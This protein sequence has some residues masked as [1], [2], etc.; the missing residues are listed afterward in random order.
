MQRSLLL[1]DVAS[2]GAAPTSDGASNARQKFDDRP[3]LAIWE[4]TQACDLVCKH[5]RA[6]AQS[7][8]DRDELT[9]S[10][11]KRLL[12]ELA[13]AR[14]PLVVL[15]GGDPA[16]RPDL[17]ELVR[18]GVGR[19]INLALTPSATPLV[20]DALVRE[21]AAAGLS[22]LAISIDGSTAEVHDEFRGVVGSFAEAQ[23]ILATARAANLQTQINT[24]IHS[25]N[26]GEIASMARLV[27]NLG[28]R[29]WSVFYLVPTGRA[30]VEMLPRAEQIEQTMSELAELA[31]LAPFAVKTTAAPHYRRVLA[32][33]AKERG[34]SAEHGVYGRAAVRINDG[35]GFVFVSHRGDIFPSGF[36]PL[37]CGNVRHESVLDVYV[38]HPVF[39][40]L[41]SADLLK[42]KCGACE[43]RNL[44]G[45]SRARAYALTGN[46]LESDELCAYVPPAYRGETARPRRRLTVTHG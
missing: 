17:L 20:T 16:K 7:A 3:F 39:Q 40:E 4:T 31:E 30:Q 2:K 26:I 37:P 33:R 45:G 11:G 34:A 41:R 14:V 12:D 27:E 28:A 15:T 9:T 18:H 6:C 43:Y 29:L 23:R 8:R 19:G 22:R 10:E 42:G 35:R 36:L 5:C 38:N 13:D 1:H 25:G 32:Q 24:S 46:Y 44:C 21:L